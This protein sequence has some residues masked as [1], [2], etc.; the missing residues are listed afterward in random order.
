[1][2]DAPKRSTLAHLQVN[3]LDR[4]LANAKMSVQVT[5]CLLRYTVSSCLDHVI[6]GWWIRT[7]SDTLSWE[8]V[9]LYL[10]LVGLFRLNL[11]IGL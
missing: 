9:G 4:A 5:S 1:M 6:W 2:E 11:F 7:C 10:R 3:Q 8:V